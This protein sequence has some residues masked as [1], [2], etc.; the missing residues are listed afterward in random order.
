MKKLLAEILL[1]SSIL[2]STEVFALSY[3][4][5]NHN[6]S[7]NTGDT[8]DM[9]KQACGEPSSAVTKDETTSQ[10]VQVVEWTYAAT[11]PVTKDISTYVPVLVLVFSD[12]LWFMQ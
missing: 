4:C 1:T 11:A 12:L 3:Y 8:A 9:V 7:V 5:M 2:C 6:K 10:P